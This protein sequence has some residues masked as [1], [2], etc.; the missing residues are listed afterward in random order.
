L[1]LFTTVTL[2]PNGSVR[3]AAVMAPAFIGAQL[4]D[5]LTAAGRSMRSFTE[6]VQRENLNSGAA[7]SCS[8]VMLRTAWS[9]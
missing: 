1:A 3:W 2:V 6:S 8:L 4:W 5:R 7:L 9:G